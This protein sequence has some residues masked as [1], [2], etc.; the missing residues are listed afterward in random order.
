MQSPRT[1]L[2]NYLNNHDFA[3]A[4]VQGLGRAKLHVV[5]HG[6]EDV[7]DLV[8]DACL[9]DRSYDPQCEGNR[10]DWL[11]SLFYGSTE[12]PM[13]Q[14]KILEALAVETHTWDL[15]QLCRLAKEMGIADDTGARQAL[16]KR[17]LEI[18][19]TFQDDWIGATEW[20][21]IAGVAGMLDLARIYGERLLQDADDW[22]N[23]D[24][25][26]LTPNTDVL[27]VA[28]KQY[29]MKEASLQAYWNYLIVRGV[30]QSEE[31]QPQRQKQSRPRYAIEQILHYA[32][33]GTRGFP[34]IYLSFGRHAT[35]DELETVYQQLIE[36]TDEAVQVRLLWVFR[37]T[38]MPRLNDIFFQWAMGTNPDLRS[39]AIAALAQITDPQVHQLARFKATNGQI[40]GADH[41]ALDLFIRNYESSDTDLIERSFSSIV[42]NSDDAHSIG[43]SIVEIAEHQQDQLFAPILKI[44][45]EITPCSICRCDVI[46]QLAKFQEFEQELVQE[47]LFD[48][49]EN[50][51][52]LAQESS[53]GHN[54]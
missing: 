11:F 25:L 37:R 54:L 10:A 42:P 38:A 46:K 49:N 48:S 6:L 45:Y 24:L 32:Q 47:C 23:E 15:L 31:S 52:K 7:A 17:V 9:H 26:L 27:Q 44:V 20:I 34:G 18:A 3:I 14:Q 50:I 16:K 39:A 22:V 1:K 53:D 29:A 2:P 4:L 36:A 41:N 33:T 51:R 5:D 8:L 21:E 35:V 43:A 12:Y 28:L 19:R 40:V 13:F 30:M